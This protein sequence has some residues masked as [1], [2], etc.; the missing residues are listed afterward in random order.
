[1]CN[2]QRLERDVRKKTLE[3]NDYN[4]RKVVITPAPP[5]SSRPAGRE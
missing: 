4:L 2:R 5:V 1:M 3:E